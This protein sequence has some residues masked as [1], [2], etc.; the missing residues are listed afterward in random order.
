MQ[1]RTKSPQSSITLIFL[2]SLSLI[3]P[4]VGLYLYPYWTGKLESKFFFFLKKRQIKQFFFPDSNFAVIFWNRTFLVLVSSLQPY[5]S[6]LINDTLYKS[7]MTV[8]LYLDRSA[9]VYSPVGS[10]D[11]FLILGCMT[12]NFLYLN[13]STF[14]ASFLWRADSTIFA[15]LNKFPGG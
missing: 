8:K 4:L 10:S 15:K 3:L 9:M 7:I 2:G 14:H 13:F 5:Y 6:S 12:S 11:L 1:F